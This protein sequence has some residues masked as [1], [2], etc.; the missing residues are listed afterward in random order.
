M[1]LFESVSSYISVLKSLL[2]K[3][4]INFD[5][6]VWIPANC[7]KETYRWDYN[8]S[9]SKSE[10]LLTTCHTSDLIFIFWCWLI[11]LLQLHQPFDLKLH[12]LKYMVMKAI[13][14]RLGY[15]LWWVYLLLTLSGQ[16]LTEI[17]FSLFFLRNGILMEHHGNRSA[18]WSMLW[19]HV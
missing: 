2:H 10:H 14:S 11:A 15:L 6:L 8:K 9:Q 12:Q 13:L 3:S 1:C 17:D 7:S 5:L 18:P 16:Q 19:D 4:N